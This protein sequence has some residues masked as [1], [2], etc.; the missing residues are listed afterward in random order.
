VGKEDMMFGNGGIVLPGN[1]RR[2]TDDRSSVSMAPIKVFVDDVVS[3]RDSE[4]E[5]GATRGSN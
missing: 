5:A 1:S 2:F 3:R 4:F